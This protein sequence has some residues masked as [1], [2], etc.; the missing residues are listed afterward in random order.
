MEGIS[1]GGDSNLP[2]PQASAAQIL[3]WKGQSLAVNGSSYTSSI[4]GSA[5]QPFS[6]DH[7]LGTETGKDVLHVAL[8]DQLVSGAVLRKAWCVMCNEFSFSVNA[9]RECQGLDSQC[10]RQLTCLLQNIKYLWRLPHVYHFFWQQL[11]FYRIKTSFPLPEVRVPAKMLRNTPLQATSHI[12]DAL[13][14][15]KVN[16]NLS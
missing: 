14:N 10:E 4:A 5:V 1:W 7:T 3:K 8:Y 13:M 2:Y 16:F 12:S 11:Y 6:W 15:S 9:V